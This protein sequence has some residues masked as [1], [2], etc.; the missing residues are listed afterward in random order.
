MNTR[1]SPEYFGHVVG[2]NLSPE[3][4][5]RI[6]WKIRIHDGP[7]HDRKVSIEQGHVPHGIA[8]GKDIRFDVREANG[9]LV[10]INATI[11]G[12]TR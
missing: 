1:A 3:D 9:E 7:N 4:P 5:S 11:V 10:A 2:F 12:Q 8:R 6:I